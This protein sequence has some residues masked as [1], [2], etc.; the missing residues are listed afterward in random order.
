MITVTAWQWFALIRPVMEIHYG[1]LKLFGQAPAYY[2]EGC[3]DG[4]YE[5]DGVYKLGGRHILIAFDGF[6]FELC[7]GQ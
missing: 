2:F 1:P 5:L 6:L 4:V 7:P 3:R